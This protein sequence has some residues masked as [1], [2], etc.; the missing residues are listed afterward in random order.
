MIVGKRRWEDIGIGF[1]F[2]MP[3]EEEIEKVYRT[4]IENYRDIDDRFIDDIC[5]SNDL[6]ESIG[7]ENALTVN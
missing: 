6:N 2:Q 7:E 3:T 4:F 1:A 5:V